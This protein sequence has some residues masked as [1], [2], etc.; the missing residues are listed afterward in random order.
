MIYRGLPFVLLI[1]M[2]CSSTHPITEAPYINLNQGVNGVRLDDFPTAVV[3]SLKWNDLASADLRKFGEEFQIAIK[4]E[5]KPYHLFRISNS[6]KDPGQTILFWPKPDLQL[7]FITVE[8]MHDFLNGMCEDYYVAGSYEYCIPLFSKDVNWESTFS[9]LVSK[10]IWALSDGVVFD[11]DST[12]VNNSWSMI[13]EVRS[14]MNYRTYSHENPDNYDNSLESVNILAVAAQLRQI[15][16]NFTPAQNYDLYTGITTGTK[17]SEFRPCNSDETWRFDGEISE[18]IAGDGLPV[19][20]TEKENIR[21]HIKVEGTIRDEWYAQR[22]S[23]GFNKI[24]TPIHINS[25]SVTS[26]T[27]CTK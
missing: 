22:N 24:I 21:F 4:S 7:G 9:N 1:W 3:D 27:Q 15:A 12:S 23:T 8:N 20:V 14:G 16:N 26:A 13:F 2:A 25:L 19:I 5:T 6:R 18:L 11:V 10:N 17:G